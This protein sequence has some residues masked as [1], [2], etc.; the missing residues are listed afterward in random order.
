MNQNTTLFLSRC[1]VTVLLTVRDCIAAVEHAFRLYGEKRAAPPG[2]LGL[3]GQDGAFHIKAGFLQL[4]RSYFA[5]KVNANYP[6]NG[7]RFGLPTIQGVIVLCDAENGRP[8]AI[9][10][11]IEVTARRTAAATAV[12][13]KYLARRESASLTLCGCGVQGQAQV[14]ALAAVLPLRRVFAFDADSQRAEQLAV[15]LG[16]ELGI[17]IRA[18]RD[19]RSSVRESDAC[20]T[21]TTS[22]KPLLTDADVPPGMFLAA[23]GADHPE[24]QELDP[25]LMANCTIVADLVEQRE[26]RRPA[27]RADIGHDEYFR[28]ACGVGGGSCRCQARKA[29][30]GRTN[31]LRQH[32]HGLTRRCRGCHSLRKSNCNRARVGG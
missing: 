18:V 17:E 12:A 13:A 1:D 2:M 9:M 31:H 29:V 16:R 27:S 26:H 23:V 21:C 8:L 24:K 22:R 30:A 11:S 25:V 19:L 28:S 6:E 10:D 5:A 7:P 20:V 15:A 32:R 4:E 3:H 14:R